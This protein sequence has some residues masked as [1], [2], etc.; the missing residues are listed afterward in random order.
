MFKN[1]V[2]TRWPY[3]LELGSGRTVMKSGVEDKD[4]PLRKGSLKSTGFG[5]VL[6]CAE[7]VP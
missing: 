5:I 4:S 2:I 1:D 7:G 3:F 6:V